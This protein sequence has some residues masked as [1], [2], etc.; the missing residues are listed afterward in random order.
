MSVETMTV[1]T[2]A[3]DAGPLSAYLA[4]PG[5]GGPW[6]GVLVLHELFGLNDDMRRIARRFAESGYV[7]MAPDLLSHGNKATCLTR[8]LTDLAR[9]ARGRSLDDLIAARQALADRPEV[10]GSRVAVAG[11]CMGGTFALVLGTTGGFQAAA[12]NYG[13][14]P[15]ERSEL[16]G[17]CPVV[18]S[19]GSRDRV[20]APMGERLAEHLAAL[21]VPH[22]Y[23]AYPDAGHSFF[24]W[25][26]V[27]GWMAKLP[28]PMHPG[29][30]EADAED[31]WARTLDFFATHV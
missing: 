27:P 19:Y 4:R 21:G 24:S 29:Y 30:S 17:L 10:D 18:A 31:A 26:N 25:D 13:G 9:G 20:F 15:K 22:D 28:S 23:K 7:A 16:D 2:E 3:V 12:V 5:G 11:Y 6:P 1:T 14:V 8:L